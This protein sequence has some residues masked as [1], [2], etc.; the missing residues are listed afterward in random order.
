MEDLDL[1]LKINPAYA[2]AICKKGDIHMDLEKYE[3]AERFYNQAGEV[4]PHLA[5]LGEKIKRAKI[6][7]KKSKQKDLYKVLGV[8]KKADER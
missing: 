4:D 1:A 7:I 8:D 6:E 2:K 5:G 3:E